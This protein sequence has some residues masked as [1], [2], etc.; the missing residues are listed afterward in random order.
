MR[1]EGGAWD[2]GP[3]IP[4][5]NETLSTCCHI[6]HLTPSWNLNA[7]RSNFGNKECKTCFFLSVHRGQPRARA[8]ARPLVIN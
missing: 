2:L 5:R 3:E 6:K 8:G 4:I 1:K 7:D